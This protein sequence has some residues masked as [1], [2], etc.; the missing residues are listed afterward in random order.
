MSDDLRESIAAQFDKIEEVAVPVSAVV[1]E[2]VFK[3][4]PQET[5]EE[6]RARDERGRFA[7]KE[8]EQ[9]AAAEVVQEQQAAP[10]VARP[11]YW[12]KEYLPL[13]EKLN[14]GAAITPEE[15]KQ[16]AAYNVQRE[17]EF[18]KG[19]TG[20]KTEA[21]TFK[22]V[23]EAMAP[24]MPDLQKNN[25]NPGQWISNLGNAHQTLVYGTP[26]QKLEMFARLAQNYGVPLQAISQGPGIDPIVPA[27]MQQI[28]ELSSQVK[29]VSSWREQQDLQT[30]QGSIK[31]FEDAT[32][33]PHFDQVRDT[34]AQLI[35]S[36][37]T[38]DLDE[39]YS[40]AVRFNDDV[41]KVEQERQAKA[42]NQSQEKAQAV[43][44]AK[45]LNVS[46]RSAAPSGKA[47]HV[48]AND[49][50]ALVASQFDALERGR[51]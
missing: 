46:S 15:A 48:D 24:F 8:Q 41:W 14:T 28:Q 47:N 19:V 4:S 51:A 2:P 25:M 30:I 22:A 21:Q 1:A 12:K 42:N 11:K 50:R 18:D 7:R 29:N 17:Q 40:K 13:W 34:M 39:A 38:T 44:K 9:Q 43:A 35:E 5:A 33:Y 49:L 20:Y 31:K 37:M 26:D 36:G 6:A 3:D 10:E 45:A 27:L 32:R 23:Q 16:L